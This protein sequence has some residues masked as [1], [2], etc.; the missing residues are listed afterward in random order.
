MSRT[1]QAAKRRKRV[2]PPPKANHTWFW[3]VGILVVI[4]L[5]AVIAVSSSGGGN[6]A[7]ATAHETGKVSVEGTPLAT[8]TDPQNDSAVGDSIPSLS[9]VTFDGSPMHIGPTGKPQ[10]IVFLS[11]SCPHCQ[12]EVPRIVALH[13]A[14][15]L[16]GVDVT[17]VTT[18]TS[19]DLP[20]YPPSAWLKR[21]HWPYPVMVDS[22]T[23]TAAQAYGLP[24]FPYF[25]FV[26]ANGNV[27]GRLAGEMPP[28]QLATLFQELRDGKKIT[29]PSSGASTP[30][31]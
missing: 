16:A 27:A 12:A 30:A 18:N 22:T 2:A 14:G 31:P 28:S 13:K 7:K 20:N 25:V 15:K 8:L 21:E 3:I 1:M 4:G 5:A 6:T 17:A 11:H 24:G 23:F 9:G 10:V 26:D 29:P 19:P